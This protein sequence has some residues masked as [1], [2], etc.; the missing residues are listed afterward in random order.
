MLG[1]V[2]YVKV[3]LTECRAMSLLKQ[4]KV[5]NVIYLETTVTYPNQGKVEVKNKLNSVSARYHDVGKVQKV[6]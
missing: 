4:Q 6:L 1:K 3:M 5:K 2:V